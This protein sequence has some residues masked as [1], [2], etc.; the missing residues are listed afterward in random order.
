[1]IRVGVIGCGSIA[2]KRHA[3]EYSNNPDVEIAG[4]TDFNTDRAR[5]MA[6]DF[7]G[8]VYESEDEMLSD[9]SIDA[10]SVCVANA[11]HA[12]ISI[13]ALNHKKHVL[14]EKPMALSVADAGQMISESLRANKLL[15]IVNAFAPVP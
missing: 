3:A 2:R 12:A 10:V 8:R 15:F 1:M 7:G 6:D 11:Y 5:K 9:G 13:K 14:C 4:F